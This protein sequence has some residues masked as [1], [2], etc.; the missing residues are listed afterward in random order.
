MRPPK[1]PTW[2]QI[3]VVILGLAIIVLIGWWCGGG[4][5]P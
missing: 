1:L 5:S 3:I 4:A 2:A